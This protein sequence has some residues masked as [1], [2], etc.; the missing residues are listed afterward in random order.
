[1]AFLLLS[2]LLLLLGLSFPAAS[3]IDTETWVGA[4]YT[5]SGASNQFWLWWWPKYAMQVDR[6]LGFARQYLNATVIRVF[7]HSLM[8]EENSTTLLN[9]TEQLL[10]TA[11][12]HGIQVGF[13]LYDD[14]WG[15]Q[16]ANLT[17]QCVPTKGVHNGCWKTSPQGNA[18]DSVERYRPYVEGM[19]T[20]YGNDTARVV[21]IETFNEPNDSNFS[22]T[23]RDESYQW[24]KALS[25]RVPILALWDDHPFTDIVDIHAYSVDFASTWSPKVLSNPEKGALITEAGAR[26]YQLTPEDA[27]SPLTVLHFLE[28]M[29]A[30]KAQGKVPFV[31]GVMLSWELMV[32]NSNTRWHW[33]SPPGAAEPAIPWCGLLFP[34]GQ[35]VSLTEQGVLLNYTSPGWPS[36]FL[37]LEKFFPPPSPSGNGNDPVDGDPFLTLSP[38][39][40]P[41]FVP[42][43]P[44]APRQTLGNAVVEVAFWMDS[45]ATSV[46]LV[47]RANP[48]NPQGGQGQVRASSCT[49]TPLNNTNACPGAVG[50]HNFVVHPQPGDDPVD[51]CR[52]ACCGDASCA[53][54]TLFNTT[55]DDKSCTCAGAPCLCCWMKP[56]SC[57]GRV[58]PLEGC[59]SG[60]LPPPPPAPPRPTPVVEHSYSITVNASTTSLDCNGGSG[61]ATPTRNIATWGARDSGL[62]PI[63]GGW[64]KLEVS[65]YQGVGG[66]H[67][68]VW[69]NAFSSLS[70][71]PDTDC[72]GLTPT[73]TA[74]GVQAFDQHSNPPQD[75]GM[76]VFSS[77][78]EA[79]VDYV[80]ARFFS[81]WVHPNFN[82]CAEHQAGCD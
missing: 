55:F 47:L 27:G 14:C 76:A 77:G 32:G 49:S 24:A 29:R 74:G 46:T 21:W 70:G 69:L 13:V 33:G 30:L 23:L 38:T 68:W 59:T 62:A 41:Y 42:F 66:I 57:E 35:P 71:I 50:E 39:A 58:V 2:R 4:E 81:P 43:L 51:L 78:G 22:M 17:S 75:G 20:A 16:G 10:I 79:R 8:W 9:S 72:C 48:A 52:S 73:A 61:D 53:A 82:P 67:L 28:G 31:P 7:L 6:E 26:W 3:F 25:P 45:N 64:N 44:G 37:A 80:S 54:W 63:L 40:P 65:I 60:F 11:S 34:D 36:D 12:S 15:T 56:A 5:P 1:M 19:V 18:R